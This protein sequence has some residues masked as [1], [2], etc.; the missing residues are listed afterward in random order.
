MLSA[1]KLDVPFRLRNDKNGQNPTKKKSTKNELLFDED[2]DII[3]DRKDVQENV[4]LIITLEHQLSTNLANVGNQMWRGSFYL[5]DYLFHLREKELK[6][7]V[8]QQ[9]RGAWLELGAGTGM[10]SIIASMMHLDSE[11]SLI[12]ATDLPE[13]VPLTKRNIE[14]NGALKSVSVIPFDL[15]ANDIPQCISECYLELILAADII[16]DNSL[17]KGI[18]CTIYALILKQLNLSVVFFQM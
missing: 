7:E 6:Q 17:T 4:E 12:Y 3:V 10:V 11:E 1:L 15:I 18:V 5:S 16:Y 9:N 8:D 14:R 2:G 13:I